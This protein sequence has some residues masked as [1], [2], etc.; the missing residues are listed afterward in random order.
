M[1]RSNFIAPSQTKEMNTTGTITQS[2]YRTYRKVEGA[3]INNYEWECVLIV[4][5]EDPSKT[6]GQ[7]CG[8]GGSC[9]D[10]KFSRTM[11]NREHKVWRQQTITEFYGSGIVD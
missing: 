10:E 3:E 5:D 11:I 2:E 7:Y 9:N 6:I 4:T 8:R 1:R